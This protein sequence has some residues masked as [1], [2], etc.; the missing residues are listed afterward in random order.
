MAD[1][2]L[3]AEGAAVFSLANPVF[4]A[5]ITYAVVVLLKTMVMSFLTV[6]TRFRYKVSQRQFL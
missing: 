6:V 4:K 2:A 5:F 3:P 1:R